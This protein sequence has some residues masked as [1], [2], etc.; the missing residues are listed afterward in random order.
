MQTGNNRL[1]FVFNLKS[2]ISS[3]RPAFR[4]ASTNGF[5]KFYYGSNNTL[6]PG[7]VILSIATAT[8]ISFFNTY[9]LIPANT[10]FSGYEHIFILH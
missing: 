6:M 8:I 3:V 7:S 9:Q 10:I 1:F 5:F 4:L 2:P